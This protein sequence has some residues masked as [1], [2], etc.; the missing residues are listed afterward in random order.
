MGLAARGATALFFMTGVWATVASWGFGASNM[1]PA[2]GCP[3][4]ALQEA[5]PFMGILLIL[6]SF[7]SIIGPRAV[8]TLGGAVS[9]L[10]AAITL[11]NWAGQ[12]SDAFAALTVLSLLSLIFSLLALRSRRS[13]TEQANPMNL[14]VFG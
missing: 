11:Y 7:A 10:V 5:V 3:M 8:F 9:A 12:S 2:T 14:P 13:L 1:C 4:P 6:V